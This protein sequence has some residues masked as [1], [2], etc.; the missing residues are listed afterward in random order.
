MAL[1]LM[2]MILRDQ[3]SH[4]APD[5]DSLDLRN[6]MVFLCQWHHMTER[7]MQHLISSIFASGM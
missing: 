2:P 7:V 4:A 6:L 5:F 3:K 1:T